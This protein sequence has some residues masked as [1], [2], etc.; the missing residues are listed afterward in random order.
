LAFALLASQSA[1]RQDTKW[2]PILHDLGIFIGRPVQAQHFE[3]YAGAVWSLQAGTT[4]I[5]WTGNK[6]AIEAVD[7][8]GAEVFVQRID[9]QGG[10]SYRSYLIA[11]SSAR[12]ENAEQMIEQASRLTLA[13][14]DPNSTSGYLVPAYALF[15]KRGQEP[16]RIFKR[17]FTA[18]HEDSFKAVASG[19]ADVGT[20]ASPLYEGMC[21]EQPRACAGLQVIWR[22]DEIPSDPLVWRKTLP[23]AVKAQI[24]SFFLAYGAERADKPEAR[25]AEE[26]RNLA[27][28]GLSGFR[29]SDDRQLLVARQIELARQRSLASESRSP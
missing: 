9:A 12:I 27:A 26:R 24:K 2:M 19:R 1:E 20:I 29:T 23:E 21:R 22:S 3:D 15:A 14:G 17:V 28:V 18:N 4:D 7:R 13:Y 11:A 8:G 16:R 6:L 5:A 25:L 10:T